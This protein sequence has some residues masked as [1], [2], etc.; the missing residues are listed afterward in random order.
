[1][2][3]L[4][5]E[6]LP[7]Q[8]AVAVVGGGI[9]GVSIAHALAGRGVDVALVERDT[10]ASGASG[11]NDGQLL[12]EAAEL[13]S[14]MSVSK[15]RAIARDVLRFKVES[16][17]ALERF[18]EGS[19]LVEEVEWLRRGSYFLAST[20][21][22]AHELEESARLLV[23]DGFAAEWHDARTACRRIDAAGFLGGLFAPGDA[24][25]NPLRLTRAIARVAAAKGARIIEQCEVLE[26]RDDALVT[27][28]GRLGAEIIVLATNAWTGE[29]LRQPGW[30][31]PIRGQILATSPLPM[32]LDV[33]CSTNFGYE[34]WRQSKDGR[35]VAGGF[36][37]TAEEE[38]KGTE[39]RVHDAVQRRIEEYILALY[40]HRAPELRVEQ[41]WCGIMG[42][43][44]DGLPF[45]GPIP[46]RPTVWLAGGFTGYGM[47]LGFGFGESIAESIVDG[48]TRYPQAPFATSRLV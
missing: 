12:L 23:E 14:R 44:K 42:F 6:D 32:F 16:Q 25:V 22:E 13:Y 3:V 17:D 41:R 39:L 19:G 21:S 20:P 2:R 47:S 27:R 9:A 5:E 34:Y 29:L 30:I 1:M 8:V 7:K 38:E 46:G 45:L 26:V 4:W 37:W 35:L 18:L 15:G 40:R 33:G 48:R 11:K 10:V 43:S 28:R 36:R 24:L 31:W